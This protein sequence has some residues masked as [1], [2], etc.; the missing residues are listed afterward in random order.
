[1][2]EANKLSFDCRKTKYFLFYKPSRKNDL[3]KL[4]IKK[5]KLESVVSIKFFTVLLD[6]NQ[7]WKD[8]AISIET[9]VAKTTGL[10]NSVKLVLEKIS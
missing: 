9:K 4:L 6:E 7:S 2:F 10:L 5:H 1:M 3:P 8:R